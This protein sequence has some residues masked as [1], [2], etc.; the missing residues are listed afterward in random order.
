MVTSALVLPRPRNKGSTSSDQ[1]QLARVEVIGGET[2]PGHKP[3]AIATETPLAISTILCRLSARIT[4]RIITAPQTRCSDQ[5]TRGPLGRA[6]ITTMK[7]PHHYQ[8]MVLFK[9]ATNS[10]STATTIQIFTTTIIV[11]NNNPM[12]MDHNPIWWEADRSH[13]WVLSGAIIK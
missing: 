6:K 13:P 2:R 1:R 4:T 12:W 5:I 8:M 9:D 11:N 7:P 3:T 10:R